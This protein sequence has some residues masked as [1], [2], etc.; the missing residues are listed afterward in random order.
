[1]YNLSRFRFSDMMDLRARLR[2]IFDDDPATIAAAGERVVQFL[3]RELVDADGKPAAALVRLFKTHPYDKLDELRKNF[4]RRMVPDADQMQS[5]RCL[6]LVATAGDL[7][8]WNSPLNSRGHMAIALTSEKMVE[9]APMISQLI[10]QMGVKVSTVLRPDPA[11]LLDMRDTSH[12]VFHVPKA[13]GSPFIV[14]QNEF[15]IPYQIESV[16]GFG[17]MVASGD[18]FATIL[19]SKVPISAEIADL[20]KVVGLNM[21]LALLPM[22][23]KPIF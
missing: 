22:A 19:F 17:G 20:F 6:V 18:L 13:L 8:E 1:V 21:K 15:V 3:Y 11:L 9:E 4:V 14:A 16:I 5:L 10:K 23:R 2:S 7:D 12:N